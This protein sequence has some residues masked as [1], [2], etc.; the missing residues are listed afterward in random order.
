MKR[1]K[2]VAECS[3]PYIKG[4]AEKLGEVTYCPSEKFTPELVKEADWLIIRSTTKCNRALLEGSKVQLITSATIGFDHID[5]HFCHEAGITWYNAPG[6]NAEA[7]AQY[8]ATAMALRAVE[9]GW[10]PCGKVIGIVGVGNVGRKVAR[11]ARALGMKVLLNDPPRAR[12]EGG[13][14]FVSLR[15]IAEEA[16]IIAF[17]VPLIKEGRDRTVHLL[18]DTLVDELQR[19]PI[20]MNACRGPVTDTSALLRGLHEGKVA[21]TVIDCWEGEPH[22]SQELLKHTLLGTPHI[23]GF[24]AQGKANGARTCIEHGLE[25]FGLSLDSLAPLYPTP[26]AKPLLRLST[27]RPLWEAFLQIFD[28]RG[29]DR[30]LRE[31]SSVFETLRREYHYPYEPSQ[32]QLLRSEIGVW[33]EAAEGIGFQIVEG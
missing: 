1:L 32:Y 8:F 25:H 7:V 26:L 4:V 21:D 23:A 18:D 15:E 14:G 11:N 2:I 30:T 10:S 33:A 6:C 13:D 17:H 31:R 12:A 29:V 22:I 20:I 28:I 24:S 27:P 5:T 9:C 19:Q 16:D 3:V